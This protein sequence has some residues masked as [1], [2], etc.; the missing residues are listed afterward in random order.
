MDFAAVDYGDVVQ[1]PSNRGWLDVLAGLAK[2]FLDGE[3]QRRYGGTSGF[4]DRATVNARGQLRPAG[5][6]ATTAFFYDARDLLAN[7]V[8][9]VVVA[10]TAGVV[11]ALARR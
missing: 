4:A 7:P 10:A 3:I 9:W 1:Q 11:I 8:T 5:E 6:P 2:P